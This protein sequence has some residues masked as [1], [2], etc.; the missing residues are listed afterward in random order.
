MRIFPLT[1]LV[2]NVALNKELKRLEVTKE[3][4]MLENK[5]TFGTCAVFFFFFY[6]PLSFLSKNY[7]VRELTQLMVINTKRFHNAISTVSAKATVKGT[8][9]KHHYPSAD[10]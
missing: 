1:Y 6:L 7:R 2:V 3:Q 9:V 4:Q 10:A 5:I 8:G